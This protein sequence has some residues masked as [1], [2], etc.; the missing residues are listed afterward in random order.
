MEYKKRNSKQCDY[1]SEDFTI[2]I[3]VVDDFKPELSR[4][5][6]NDYACKID[7]TVLRKK[8][9]DW[10]NC[11]NIKVNNVKRK[12][13]AVMNDIEDDDEDYIDIVNTYME[14]YVIGIDGKIAERSNRFI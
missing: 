11:D 13:K 7:L 9:V 5:M 12:I 6:R 2:T 3:K 1:I 10:T 14:S 4:I 8:K